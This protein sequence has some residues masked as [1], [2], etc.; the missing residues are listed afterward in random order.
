MNHLKD[1]PCAS[2][3]L[4]KNGK[5]KVSF[6]D[7][8]NLLCLKHCLE[9]NWGQYTSGFIVLDDGGGEWILI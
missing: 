5:M 2:F 7:K 3:S 8:I 9:M 1:F 4:D 6:V